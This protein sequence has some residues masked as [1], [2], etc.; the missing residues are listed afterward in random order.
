MMLQK[1]STRLHTNKSLVLD[2]LSG[3]AV[4]DNL[5]PVC[6]KSLLISLTDLMA[7]VPFQL[8]SNKDC[9]AI[10]IETSYCSVGEV[11]VFEIKCDN[12]L[13]D[14][15]SSYHGTKEFLNK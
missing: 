14:Q 1:Y 6:Y 9:E 5:I 2:T 4:K 10:R 12:L 13:S 15:P 11:L 8:F 3:T 7:K